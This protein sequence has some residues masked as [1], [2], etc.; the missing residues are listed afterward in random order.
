MKKP[1]GQLLKYS[2]IF[3][4]VCALLGVGFFLGRIDLYRN[5]TETLQNKYTLT[6]ELKS[7]YKEVDVN[8]LWEAWSTIEKEYISS[9]IDRQDL[10]Y[11]AVK[12]MVSSLNDPYTNF[13]TP[14]DTQ[15][16]QKSNE[17]IYEGI[18]ATLRQEG[19][20]VVIETV[21]DKSP[22]QKA[23]LKS[24]DV[25]ME[26]DKVDMENKTVFE[27]VSVIRGTA[28]T[29]V[30]LKIWRQST[31]KELVIE[32]T[33]EKID[34]DNVEFEKVDSNIG[35]VLI[36]KFTEGDVSTFNSLWDSVVKEIQD[37][38]VKKLVIDLR[39]NPGGYVSSVEYILGD[40]IPNGSVIFMEE[41]KGGI[42]IE[43]KV[44]RTGRLLDIPIVVLVNEGSASASEIFTGAIQDYNRGKVIGMKTVGKG[45]EQKILSLSDG[46]MLQ[47][48]FQKWLTPKGRNI[49]KKEPI[50]PE[51]IEEDYKKQDEK[52]LEILN[53]LN[54]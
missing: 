2:L 28:G 39:N 48:V 7:E 27:T 47:V 6:G 45:V 36:H 9:D 53:N 15:E 22:A 8:I 46:S 51:I 10:V 5:I 37:S 26:V 29:K 31:Q 24:A 33:R 43:H 42:K 54:N 23:E 19:S 1:T 40:F 52:A 4:G 18:G 35:K 16:Y 50:V 17:G 21:M 3:I 14:T 38:G 20:Y 49:T 32:I 12:G 30:E 13:L 44:D 11:G 41:N 25:I 34:I